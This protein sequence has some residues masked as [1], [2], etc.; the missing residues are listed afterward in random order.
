MPLHDKKAAAEPAPQW[1]ATTHWSVVIAAGRGDSPQ[2]ASA[3]EKLCRA[4]WL[5]IYSYVRQRGHSPHDAL[6]LAQGFFALLLERNDFAAANPHRGR[7]RSFLLAALNHFLANQ[8]D[9]AMAAKRGGGKVFISLDDDTVEKRYQLEPITELSPDKI[10]ERR[11]ALA[12]MEQAMNVLSAEFTQSG[13]ARQFELLKKFLTSE[14]G[15]AEYAAIGHELG[16]TEGAVA[17]SV[18]R[19]RQ[20]YRE[21]VRIEVAQT[22]ASPLEIEDEMRHL[23]SLL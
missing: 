6:D 19:L 9:R 23:L 14:A 18:Y 4:Y 20:R 1:F 17:V 22:V 16:L 11:W 7:F 12:V 13:K 3:L 15:P 5:P 2:A 10:Y 21:L 8:H